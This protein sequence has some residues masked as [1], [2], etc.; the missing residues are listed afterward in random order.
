MVGSRRGFGVRGIWTS[1]ESEP[2]GP[3]WNLGL[4]GARCSVYTLVAT[5]AWSPGQGDSTDFGRFR[6]VSF[7]R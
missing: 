2:P 4:G 3:T 1:F 7:G 5:R 6:K